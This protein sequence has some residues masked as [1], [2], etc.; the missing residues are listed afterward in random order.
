MHW[1]IIK[2]GCWNLHSVADLLVLWHTETF[3][4]SDKINKLLQA[5]TDKTQRKEIRQNNRDGNRTVHLESLLR[6]LKQVPELNEVLPAK[7]IWWVFYFT[8]APAEHPT[9][10]RA[11]SKGGN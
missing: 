2:K 9:K 6:W 11:F 7:I 10:L 3:G 5:T 1:E 4:F 8:D